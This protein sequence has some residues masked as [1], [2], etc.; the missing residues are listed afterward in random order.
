MTHS[1]T[2][3]PSIVHMRVCL[4]PRCARLHTRVAHHTNRRPPCRPYTGGGGLSPLSG[5]RMVAS[6][7]LSCAKNLCRKH[8]W[9]ASCLLDMARA[10]VVEATSSAK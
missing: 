6:A 5:A 10:N 7:A 2:T 1:H 9:N 4:V 3:A 8:G